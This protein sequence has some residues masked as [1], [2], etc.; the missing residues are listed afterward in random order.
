MV[1]LL[2]DEDKPTPQTGFNTLNFFADDIDWMSVKE[3]LQ[4]IK[5][6]D[7]MQDE[8][9]NIVLEKFYSLCYNV[10][11]EKV[12]LRQNNGQIKISK[13]ERYRRTLTKRRR[14]ITK[15]FVKCRSQNQKSKI[16]KELLEIEKK[17][18]KS[19]RESKTHIEEKAVQAIKTNSKYFFSYAKK[20]SK[21]TSKVGHK[22]KEMAELLSHGKMRCRM[23]TPTLFLKSFTPC[24]IMYV[25]KK[26]H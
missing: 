24:A 15:R 12:P 11:M 18:Q 7:E 13:I 22:N 3:S 20:K 9:P 23:R 6:E 1:I 25:W 8:Y 2:K 14:K 21:V 26:S 4:E 17:L 10:C 19:F 16:T 5:W